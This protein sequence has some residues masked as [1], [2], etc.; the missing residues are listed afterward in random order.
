MTFFR[1]GSKNDSK[2]LQII[3]EAFA[4]EEFYQ[5]FQEY[6]QTL[7][8]SLELDNNK[9]IDKFVKFIENSMKRNTIKVRLNFEINKSTK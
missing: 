9:K 1:Q 4:S 8:K 5:G 3:S 6:L 7:D 2:S